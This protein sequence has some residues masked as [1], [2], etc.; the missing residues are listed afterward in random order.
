MGVELEPQT[1]LGG[2]QVRF[3]RS[4]RCAVLIPVPSLPQMASSAGPL[5]PIGSLE[6]L[7]LLFDQQDGIL[8][9]VEL[10][11]DWDHVGDQVSTLRALRGI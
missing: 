7:D 4:R 2:A 5:D 11:E 9:H 8:R 3:G 6:L 10:G 1:D